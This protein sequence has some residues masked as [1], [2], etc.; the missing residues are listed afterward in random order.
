MTL[1]QKQ[2]ATAE[3][4]KEQLLARIRAFPEVD[5]D[6]MGH[7]HLAIKVKKKAFAYYSFDHHGDSKIALW[8][9]A[10]LAEQ[11]HEIAEDPKTVYSPA[12]LGAR[13]WIAVRLDLAKVDWKTV[14]R[15]LRRAYLASAG[16]RLGG[17]L[18]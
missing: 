1:D 5:I 11:K 3:E 10:T 17:L 8:A 14:D 15:A 18:Q 6:D 16:K 12:Y 9:K 13:G 4:R 7:A 2:L